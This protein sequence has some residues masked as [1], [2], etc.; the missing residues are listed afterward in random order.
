[1]LPRLA[2]LLVACAPSALLTRDTT[3]PRPRT[4]VSVTEFLETEYDVLIVGGGNAG[5]VLASRLSAPPTGNST[6]P[7]LRVGVIEAGLHRPGDPLIDIPTVGNLLGNAEV[8]TLLGNPDYDWGFRS[9]PQESL[10]G[11]VVQ[12]PRGKVLGGSTAIHS[13]VWQRGNRADYDAWAYTFENGPEWSFDALLPY[14]ER[15]E[16]YVQSDL[17][18]PP[19]AVPPSTPSAQCGLEKQLSTVHGHDGPVQV[20]YNSYQT[21]LE[22]PA[23]Q[24]LLHALSNISGTRITANHNPD[25]GDSVSVPMFGTSRSV[26]PTTGLRSY[27]ASAYLDDAHGIWERPNLAIMTGATAS[28][29]IF[30]GTTARGVEFIVNATTHVARLA[31]GGEVILSAGALQ[32]PQLLELSGVGNRTRLEQLGIDVVI[33]LP[34]VGENLQD[35]PVTLSDFAIKEGVETLDWLGLNATHAELHKQLFQT[36]RTGALSYTAPLLAPIPLQALMTP[37]DLS[38]IRQELNVSLAKL[39]DQGQGSL[40]AMQHVQYDLL[41]QLLDA[42]DVGWVEMVLVPSG[43]IVSPPTLSAGGA[44][45]VAI[46]LY[47]FS[48][49]SVHINSTDPLAPPLI[50][51]NFLPEEMPWDAQVL[52]AGSKLVKRWFATSPI[53]ALVDKP[54][55]PPSNLTIDG[56]A[57]EWDRYMRSALRVCRGALRWSISTELAQTTNHPMG[58]TAMAPR[59]MGGVVNPHLKVYGL[60]NVRVVD[61]GIIP[62]TMGVAIQPAVYALAEK[63]SDI[64][65]ADWGLDGDLCHASNYESFLGQV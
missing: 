61:A 9:V 41:L 42:G 49:G 20:S 64:I 7:P 33:D 56:D 18:T 47:P 30:D 32:S 2:W 43:G 36:S 31:D 12:Y 21:A 13:M 40:T 27:A 25:A 45:V 19:L 16:A 11:G 26:S 38:A 62:I 37:D 10:G 51:P 3:A 14:M 58:T 60:S 6:R 17:P 23:A 39:R 54:L 57:T 52:T 63:A 34:E 5:L 50:D 28:R 1:M 4:T 59:R 8:G 24:A 22:Q 65:R 48:R 53:A 46:Q 35:H 44:T 15:S 55:Y 29:I